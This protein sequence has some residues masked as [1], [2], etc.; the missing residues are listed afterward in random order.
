MFEI[1]GMKRK[2]AVTVVV[3]LIVQQI[4]AN[5]SNHAT[6]GSISMHPE[7]WKSMTVINTG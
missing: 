7:S 3:A 1:S 5:N 2:I 4:S 6:V